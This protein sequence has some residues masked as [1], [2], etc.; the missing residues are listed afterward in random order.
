MIT[1]DIAKI[2]GLCP[3]Y[4]PEKA[5][6]VV[7]DTGRAHIT[8]LAALDL[9]I[10][11]FDRLWLVLREDVIGA[12]ILKQFTYDCAEYVLNHERLWGR[13]PDA[14][15]LKALSVWRLYDA[16]NATDTELASA[17]LDADAAVSDAWTAASRLGVISFA[18]RGHPLEEAK[19]AYANYCHARFS[20]SAAVLAVV[21]LSSRY[22]TVAHL[23]GIDYMMYDGLVEHLRCMLEQAAGVQIK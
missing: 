9:P 18:A 13:E 14:R 7:A 16:G 3:W 17:R 8:A 21:V 19:M 11:V 22:I 15:S 5:E 10:S 12:N 4:T 1:I 6:A 2:L 23:R 20:Y